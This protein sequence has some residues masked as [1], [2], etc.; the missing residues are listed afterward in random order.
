MS[1]VLIDDVKEGMILDSDLFQGSQVLMKSGVELSER[2]LRLCK[3]WGIQSL[4]IRGVDAEK[5][6][7]DFLSHVPP[8]ISARAEIEAKKNCAHWDMG[9]PLHQDF[10]Q[11][12]LHRLI[13]HALHA[14]H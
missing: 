13:E 9:L 8:E 1:A 14:T 6:E 12:H 4:N 7:Q 3:A 2:H 5:V 10:Y 11:L